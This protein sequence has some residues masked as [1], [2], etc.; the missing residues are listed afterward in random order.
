M[1]WISY[2]ATHYKNG[3]VDRIAELKSRVEKNENLNIL[4]A[5]AIGST[6]Y[7]AIEEYTND[8]RIVFGAVFLTSTNTRDYN[9]FAYNSM[10]ETVGPCERK[11]PES[12]LKL[13]TPTDSER[14]NEWRN[15]CWENIKKKKAK[16]KDPNSLANLPVGSIIVMKHW[17]EDTPYLELKKISHSGHKSPIWY[18]YKTG[19][20][21]TVKTIEEQGFKVLS[22]AQAQC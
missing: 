3:K 18:S 21:Y 19:Y 8:E 2:N 7:M 11:C 6:V 17:K 16:R 13:L 5:S 10:S 9:N 4:K 20:R 12:I 1:G 15:D 22:R 14:A